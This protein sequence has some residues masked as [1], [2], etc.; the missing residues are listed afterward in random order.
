MGGFHLRH[1]VEED[2]ILVLVDATGEQHYAMAMTRRLAKLLLAALADIEVRRRAQTAEN[3]A[4]RDAVLTFEHQTAVAEGFSSG[5]TRRGEPPRPIIA[6]PRLVH[7]IK[8]TAKADGGVVLHFDDREKT[9]TIDLDAR[10]VHSFMGGLIEIA[11][12]AGWDL[13]R[14]ASWLERAEP[15]AQATTIVH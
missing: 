5:D 8:L 4:R 3:P 12:K 10:R 14:I 15:A 6:P 2:R 13:P 1:H 9:I 11:S 7:E